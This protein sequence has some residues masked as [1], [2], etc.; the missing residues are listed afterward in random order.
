MEKTIS[1]RSGFFMLRKKIITVTCL[2]LVFCLIKL[3]DDQLV[4]V[5]NTE[6]HGQQAIVT[7]GLSP[8]TE[9]DWTVKYHVK[10]QKIY[11]ENFIPGFSFQ[12]SVSRLPNHMDGYIAVFINGKWKMN[13]HQSIFIVRNLTRGKHELTLQLKRKDGT[14][15][16]IKK[17]VF[18]VIR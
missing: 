13:A 17:N 3:S 15:Y 10:K 8:I 11:I 18:V 16:G 2:V 9:R 5:P 4:N 14:D 1:I 6:Y 7:S 12:G